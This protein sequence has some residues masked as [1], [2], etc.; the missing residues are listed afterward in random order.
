MHKLILDCDPG[1]DDMAAIILACA[2]PEIELFG[3]TTS[4]GNQ[5]AEKTFANARKVLALIG[6]E[7]VSVYRGCATPLVKP[8]T[9]APQIHGKSGLDG[10]ELPE[11]S[12]PEEKEHAVDFL[13]RTIEAHPGLTVVIT[14]PMTNIAMLLK[15]E[16]EVAG[17]VGRFVVMGGTHAMSNVTPAAEFNIYVDPEAA[18]IVFHSGVPVTLV[19]LDVTNRA[20][21]TEEDLDR[22][23]SEG[24]RVS[25]TVADLIRFFLQANNRRYRL[26]GAP[27]HDPMTIAW[28]LH[29]EVLETKRVAVNVETKGEYTRGR[30]VFD[31][32]GITGEEPNVDVSVDFDL[33]LFKKMMFDAVRYFD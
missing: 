5:T 29:P 19:T 24:G 33:P 15:K 30:T 31:F 1:H 7:D 21:F 17:K 12:V 9:T 2:S 22:M 14:G 27:L 18:R 13:Y 28:L 20:L 25:K 4:A 3:I 6:R 16:P 10:A 8:L 26:G 23:G 32:Y 11:P